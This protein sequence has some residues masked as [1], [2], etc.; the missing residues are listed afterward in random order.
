[1]NILYFETAHKKVNNV[2][3]MKHIL[4]ILTGAPEESLF[5][6]EF[7]RRISLLAPPLVPMS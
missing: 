4:K 1:M 5:F 2:F 3:Q 7:A 6:V